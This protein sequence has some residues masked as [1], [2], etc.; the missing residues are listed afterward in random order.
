MSS[1]LPLVALVVLLIIG[2]LIF[3]RI[4]G[5]GG[6]LYNLSGT[7]GGVVWVLV[8]AFLVWGG[9]YLLGGLIIIAGVNIHRSNFRI[10]KRT[11]GDGRSR[12]N[13]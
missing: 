5:A 10:A 3:R 11:F 6:I 8:G 12:L 7:L 4:P 1:L 9:S 13:G 2:E